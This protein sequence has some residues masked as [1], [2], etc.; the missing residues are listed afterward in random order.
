MFQR[1]GVVAL[2]GLA[3]VACTKA[4]PAATCD[5]GTCT[6]PN[7]PF[8]DQDGVVDGTPGACIAVTCT[9]GQFGQCD[10]SAALICNAAGNGFDE[11]ACPTGCSDDTMGCTSCVA[12]TTTCSGPVLTTCGSDGHTASTTA[13]GI[14]CSEDGGAHCETLEPQ[15]LPDVCNTTATTTAL[16]FANDEMDDTDK[17]ATCTGG[18][19]S[20]AGGPSICVIHAPTITVENGVTLT[21]FSSANMQSVDSSGGHAI[22]LVADG[23]LTI[24][25][26]VDASAVDGTN[27]PGGGTIISGTYTLSTN[28]GGG[29]GFHTAG[30]AGAAPK[31]S[32]G[33]AN[34]GPVI[35]AAELA[36]TLLGGPAASFGGGGGGAVVLISCSGQVTID[37]TVAA[38]GGGGPGHVQVQNGATLE[39]GGGGGGAG[40]YVVIQGARLAITGHVF[41]NGG[42]GASGAPGLHGTGTNGQDGQRSSSVA[43]TGAPES[44]AGGAGGNGA[45]GATAPTVG[46]GGSNTDFA[47]GGGGSVGFLQ[48]FTPSG[49]SADTGSADVSPAFQ[50]N[51]NVE[52]H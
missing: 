5:N 48:T 35:D 14:G 43:A 28:G 18:T 12:D 39:G 9:P 29:A 8:C 51:A 34:G 47:G 33:A 10:G 4:N 6:D 32:G 23:A 41:A 3:A 38:N 17:P 15:Y 42:A 52:T 30:A 24:D 1:I 36:T 7:F 46:G 31:A 19:V 50:Q 22:A 26:V 11:S 44:G 27:G 13:C 16:T 40:G 20:P 25:G 21:F 37:G 49:V 45:L 2:L